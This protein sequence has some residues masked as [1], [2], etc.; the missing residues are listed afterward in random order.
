MNILSFAQ[1]MN[2][3]DETRRS[4]LCKH[5]NRKS[6]VYQN[7]PQYKEIEDS[8]VDLSLKKTKNMIMGLEINAI[9]AEIS[10]AINIRNKLLV[11]HGYE[12]DY[13]QPIF[14]CLDCKDT[15]YI[16]NQKCHCLNKKL[17]DSQTIQSTLT[18]KISVENFD[19]FNMEL[20][21]YG[22]NDKEKKTNIMLAKHAHKE[23]LSF[24]ENFNH[25]YKN[26]LIMGQVGV[27]KT[28][29]SNCIAKAL[30]DKQKNVLYYSSIEFFKMIGSALFTE[31][32]YDCS[33]EDRNAATNLINHIINC[34]L[35]IIDDLGTE[36]TN[37]FVES[38]IFDCINTRITLK[39]STVISTN[40]SLNK[41]QEQ[42]KDRIIS[43]I[44]GNFE[45][46]KLT[47]KDLRL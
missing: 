45:H 35:L 23:A 30:I 44:I 18:N 11:D 3:Y 24:V 29:L 13:L 8:I 6:L 15:G 4:N 5:F 39:K 31:N 2:T 40:L 36:V 46:V 22:T 41:I 9:E 32:N 37:R 19:T 7:I 26:L 38:Q 10:N 42:Y 27:G 21:N 43:R 25:E 28:F 16:N 1:I 12:F 34:D 14:T 47:G 33:Q 17:F 20:Y